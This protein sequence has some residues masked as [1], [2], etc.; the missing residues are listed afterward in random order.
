MDRALTF[1][2]GGADDRFYDIDFRAMQ[3]DPIGEVRGL[4]ALARRTGHRRV[5]GRMRELVGATTPR[6]ASRS[7]RA[8][9]PTSGSTST[10]SVRCSPTYVDT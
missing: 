5:R 3:A 4:Y 10:R 8:T 9:R 6:T 2:D 7:P 1:R